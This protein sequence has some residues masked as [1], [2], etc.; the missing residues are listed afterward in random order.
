LNLGWNRPA[1]FDPGNLEIA[2]EAASALAIALEQARL[3]EELR[4]HAVELEQRLAELQRTDQHRRTLMARLVRAQERERTRIAMGVHDEPLQQMVAADLRLEMLRS[5]LTDP[6]QLETLDQLRATVKMS[7]DRLR[8]LLFDL[9]PPDLDRPG[10]LSATLRE[11]GRRLAE[12]VGV[13]VTFEERLSE[14]PSVETAVICYRI[15]HEALANIRKHAHA[16]KVEVLIESRDEGVLVQ[17]RDDGVGFSPTEV[18]A[19]PGHL[20]LFAMQERAE[21]AGG[22]LRVD[23]APGAGTTVAFWLPRAV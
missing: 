21:L 20:G 23:A 19:I 13:S 5:K 4:Q 9:H 1:A 18:R 8:R 15:T 7:I 12:E 6:E 22:W 14:E 17:V 10:G 11:S 16:A 2:Q 3:R